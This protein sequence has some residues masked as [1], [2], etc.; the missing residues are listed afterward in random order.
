MHTTAC[1]SVKSTADDILLTSRLSRHT[2]LRGGKRQHKRDCYQHSCQAGVYTSFVDLCPRS[3]ALEVRCDCSILPP[4]NTCPSDAH[5]HYPSSDVLTSSV[6]KSR[7]HCTCSTCQGQSC[8]HDQPSD[9]Q[10]P[11]KWATPPVSPCRSCC[12]TP[13]AWQ[14]PGPPH[15]RCRQW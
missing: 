3:A 15:S 8:Q 10:R 14:N 4:E 12:C 7:D 13:S 9:W 5:L 1:V 6:P 11:A 2:Q